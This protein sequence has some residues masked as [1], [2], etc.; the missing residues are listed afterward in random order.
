MASKLGGERGGTRIEPACNRLKTAG[1]AIM[2]VTLR[3]STDKELAV[4]QT[5]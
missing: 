3:L 5:G 1:I 2:D 4:L